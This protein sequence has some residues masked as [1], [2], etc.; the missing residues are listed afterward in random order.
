[1]PDNGGCRT[2][3]LA[4]WRAFGGQ[5]AGGFHWFG[6]GPLSQ[7]VSGLLS[8]LAQLLVLVIARGG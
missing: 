6:S 8:D 4:R 1:M 3:L 7:Q 5:L 2:G